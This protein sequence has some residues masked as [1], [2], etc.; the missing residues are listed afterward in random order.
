MNLSNSQTSTNRWAHNTRDLS[1]FGQE[2]STSKIEQ[3][4]LLQKSSI[5]EHFSAKPFGSS[6]GG[7]SGIG[8]NQIFQN[9]AEAIENLGLQVDQEVELD[10]P[11]LVTDYGTNAKGEVITAPDVVYRD[12]DGEIFVDGASLTDV[13]QG[14]IGDCYLMAALASI[15]KD[16]PEFLDELIT[17]NGNGTYTVH[18]KGSLGD[19]TID[20]DFP[21]YDNGG[22]NTVY[23]ETNTGGSSPELWV[24]IV[25]KAYAQGKGGY[26]N[27][28]GGL[29]HNAITEITGNNNFS[30]GTPGSFSPERLQASI[31]RGESVTASS[32]TK[33]DA[34]K[35]DLG[36]GIISNH[37]Y[38]VTE[39]RQ[40]TNGEWEVVV[41]NPWGSDR[42]TGD[43]KNDGFTVLSLEEF[44][45]N[46]R[47]TA[48]MYEPVANAA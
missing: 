8:K 18:F 42:A 24:A 4:A 41:Y 3:S 15:A 35:A 20:D 30:T 43:G 13:N 17:D 25:E 31:A 5:D 7:Y 6:I 28:V 14:Y 46:F 29:T 26:Q 38:V 39:V 48:V 23:A 27:I 2:M 45:A 9:L 11:S 47:A 32:L 12:I 33:A 16:N 44:H 1:Q 21:V 22:T 10:D 37:A 36:T 34:K 19:V 40:N